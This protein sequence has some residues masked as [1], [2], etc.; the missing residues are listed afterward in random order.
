MILFGWIF[1]T[2]IYLHSVTD[3]EFLVIVVMIV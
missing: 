1:D 2:N 3:V